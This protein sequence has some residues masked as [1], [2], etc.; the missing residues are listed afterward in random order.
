MFCQ[1][2]VDN[3][4]PFYNKEPVNSLNELAE[5]QLAATSADELKHELPDEVHMDVKNGWILEK[6][7][8]IV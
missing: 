1:L 8:H 4:Q 2:T 3:F 7:Q 5:E 6:R